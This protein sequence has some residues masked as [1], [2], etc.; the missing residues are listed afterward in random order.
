MAWYDGKYDNA[1]CLYEKRFGRDSACFTGPPITT[2][3]KPT[4][5]KPPT[6]KAPTTKAPTTKAPTT[7]ST[8][9]ST[10]TKSTTL[11]PNQCHL[12]NDYANRVKGD[13][14]V[15]AEHPSGGNC[16]FDWSYIQTIPAWTLFA[17]LPKSSQY[18]NGANCGR[19]VKIKCSCEQKQFDFACKP[20]GEETIVMVTDSCPP[21]SQ[22]DID[23]S[24]E[25]WDKIS[26]YQGPS[27]YEGT[28]DFVE[29]PKSFVQGL[30][31]MR[32]KSGS[33]RW[34]YAI[35]PFNFRYKIEKVELKDNSGIWKNL[36]VYVGNME[37]FFFMDPN[38]AILNE[39]GFDVRITNSNADVGSIHLEENDLG[40]NKEFTLDN[41]L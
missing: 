23:V 34:W 14:T 26:G 39:G 18:E 11:N 13:I 7:K 31:R 15:Y 21:C 16:D 30:T 3:K 25:A 24:Y 22:G 1:C 8:T 10:T 2:T 33:S 37:G 17:A 38:K 32:F 19:C 9:K 36:K 4:T 12:G 27:R 29:C 41:E 20:D 5:T 28:W 40:S 6:T 35:Q